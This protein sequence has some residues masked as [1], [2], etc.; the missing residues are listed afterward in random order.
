MLDV[1]EI[2]AAS[3]SG[4][5]N[6]RELREQSAEAQR[7][8]VELDKFIMQIDALMEQQDFGEEL[9]S[10]DDSVP[11]HRETVSAPETAEADNAT[12]T[13][14]FDIA[15]VWPVKNPATGGQ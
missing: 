4:V 9:L 7:Q 2:D 8:Q 3:N 11:T 5:D 14:N 10:F 15:T 6:I 1:T 12:D 13:D